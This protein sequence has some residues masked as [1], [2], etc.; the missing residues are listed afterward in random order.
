MTIPHTAAIVTKL[1]CDEDFAYTKEVVRTLADCDITPLLNQNMKYRLGELR[2]L[3]RLYYNEHDMIADADMLIVLG[4]DGMMLDYG[5]RAAE[6]EKPVLGVNLGHLGFLTAIERTE[7]ARLSALA[8]GDYR[9]EERMMLDLDVQSHSTSFHQC[10]LND[11]VIASGVCARM[12]TLSIFLGDGKQIGCRADG[13]IVSTPTGSTAYSL[14]AGG[15]IVEPTAE[16]M[17]LTPICPHTLLRSPLVLSPDKIITVSGE[18]NAES[19]DLRVSADGGNAITVPPDAQI[20]ICRSDRKAQIIK[21][22]GN[23]FYEIVESKLNR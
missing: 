10:A 15:P 13:L 23:R 22:G 5:V 16:L 17:T 8:I 11:V 1:S 14:S 12:V 2:D 7:I 4:G 9:I 18:T 3:V 21:L 19:R 6:A 20:Q